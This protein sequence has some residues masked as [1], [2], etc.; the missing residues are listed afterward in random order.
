MKFLPACLVASAL[1][2]SLPAPSETVVYVPDP[3]HSCEHLEVL[4]FGTSTLRGR[5]GP[6]N[7]HVELDRPA[8]R[9]P[10][11]LHIA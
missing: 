6:L 7:G 10:V 9:G 11:S 8:G 4:H 3:A 2:M 5:F 1:A